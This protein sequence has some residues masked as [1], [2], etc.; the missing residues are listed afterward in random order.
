MPTPKILIIGLGWASASFIKTIDTDKYDVEVFSLDNKFVY[1]PLL[2]QNIKQNNTLTLNGTD[3]NNRIKFTCREIKNLDVTNSKIIVKSGINS[4]YNYLI[5]AHGASVNTFNISGVEENCQFLKTEVNADELKKKIKSLPEKSH[6]AVIGCGLTG[7]ELIGSLLDYNKFNIHAIDALPRPIMMFS[8]KLSNMTIKLWKANNIN[9]YMNHLVSSVTSREINFVNNEKINYDL[10]IWCGGIKKSP[11]TNNIL[12][13]LK[14]E[15][16]KGIPVNS[17]LQVE[18][19]KN[20]WALGDCA[21]SGLPPTAQVAYQQGEYLARQFNNN[22]KNDI[23][24]INDIN[25]NKKKK[26]FQFNNNGQIGYIGLKQSV[27]QLPYLQAGGN[28][29]YYLNNVIHF[30]NGINLKQKINI[31]RNN[32][33]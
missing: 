7:S 16:S 3:I 5:L 22:I 4:H 18:N 20:V 12:S 9:I 11:L 33:K 6:I 32:E 10:A 29:V 23:N 15:N 28:L 24:D 26:P 31:M 1:T 19:V 2:P 27:C 25:D 14:I 8:E 30:Y 13:A 17:Y 21:S